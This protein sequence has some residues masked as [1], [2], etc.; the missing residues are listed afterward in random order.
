MDMIIKA[1]AGLASVPAVNGSVAGILCQNV[2][3]PF[4]DQTLISFSL[5]QAGFA[6]IE[7]YNFLGQLVA[8]PMTGE[9]AAGQHSVNFKAADLPAGMYLCKLYTADGSVCQRMQIVR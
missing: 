5:P 4:N 1:R 9:M 7:V 8:T 6:E 2:P 3:N